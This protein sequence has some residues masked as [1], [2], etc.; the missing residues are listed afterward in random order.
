M[1]F[2][3]RVYS[4][5]GREG[6]LIHDSE[7]LDV[8]YHKLILPAGLSD[9]ARER[10]VEAVKQTHPRRPARA[11]AGTAHAGSRPRRPSILAR[12]P[13]GVS[14]ATLRRRRRQRPL[15]ARPG[16]Q[17]PRGAGALGRLDAPHRG[18]ACAITG[19][20]PSWPPSPTSSRRSTRRPTRASAPPGCG[21]SRARPA[22]CSCASTRWW[23]S[24]SIPSRPPTRR[25]ACSPRTTRSPAPGRSRSPPTTTAPPACAARRRASAPPTSP[26]SSAVPEP[27]ASASPRATSTRRSSPPSRSSAGP[28]RSSATSSRTRRSTTR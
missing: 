20:P 8:V 3:E 11:R 1:R 27:H 4:E 7:H 17:V 14:D 16:R 9:R 19:C 22:A 26:P 21:S 15:P 25:R 2:W 5:V 12:W 24:A 18:D 10:R 6:G 13:E 28:S 23:T